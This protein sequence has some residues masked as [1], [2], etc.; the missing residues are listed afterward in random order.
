MLFLYRFRDTLG[1]SRKACTRV[2]V[3]VKLRSA[4]CYLSSPQLTGAYE[5]VGVVDL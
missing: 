3:R 5:E 2:S 1:C 4:D